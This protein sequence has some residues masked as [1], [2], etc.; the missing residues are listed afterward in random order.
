MVTILEIVVTLI[1][2]P[3]SYAYQIFA[4]LKVISFMSLSLF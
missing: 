3:H 2:K 4:N 1:N